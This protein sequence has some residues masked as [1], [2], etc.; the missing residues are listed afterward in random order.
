MKFAVIETGG[1]QYKVSEGDSI[2]VEKLPGEH[3]EGDKITFDKVLLLSDGKETKIGTPYIKGAKIEAV[4]K[5]EGKNK[6][7]MVIRFKSKSRYFKKRGHRQPFT[8]VEVG[9]IKA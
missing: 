2:K 6:K 4:F 5:E 3:K 8:K 9:A 7:I 1:K